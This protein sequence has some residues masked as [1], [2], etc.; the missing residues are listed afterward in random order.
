MSC[1]R[2]EQR[3]IAA[4]QTGKLLWK[5]QSRHCMRFHRMSCL[6]VRSRDDELTDDATQK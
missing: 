5:P 2:E 6:P 3:P 4:L 1:A